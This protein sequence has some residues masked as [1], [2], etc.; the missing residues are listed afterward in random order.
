METESILSQLNSPK[1][2]LVCGLIV[3]FVALVC[4]V[5]MVRAYRAGVKIG[6]D[7]AK[8]KRVII[9][10]ATFTVLPAV[11]ILLGVIALSGSLGTPWPWLR[12]SVIGA[13]HY[14]TQVAQG[15]AEQVGMQKLSASEMT[16]H[17]FVTIALLMSVCIIW[18][19]VLSVFFNKLYMKKLNGLKNQ[20]PAESGSAEASEG[21]ASGLTIREAAE[22]TS[23][24]GVPARTNYILF[25]ENGSEVVEEQDTVSLADMFRPEPGTEIRVEEGVI[26]NRTEI[27]I[28]TLAKQQD[29]SS[30]EEQPVIV[31]KE[32]GDITR[33]E[34]ASGDDAPVLAEDAKDPGQVLTEAAAAAAPDAPEKK[35]GFGD[36]AMSAMFIGLVSAYIGSYIGNWVSGKGRFTFA[37]DWRPIVVAL[38]SAASM[39]FFLWL[40]EKKKL[41]WLDS[42]SVA[43]SMLL[44]MLT[45]VLL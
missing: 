16:A 25:T 18:G 33:A 6:M 41:T 14:E 2:Y 24:N 34:A 26:P 19:M 37:G 44:G 28:Q 39:A 30:E 7:T 31:L 12:L 23:E 1:M 35:R 36:I 13:L 22:E 10:S 8:M 17:A 11:G 43:A 38:V 32:A 15:A 42:F 5:F 27:L 3:L 4:V 9:F 45:A 21:P 29:G 40:S 20:D